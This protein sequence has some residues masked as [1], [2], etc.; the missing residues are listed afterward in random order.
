MP[1]QSEPDF[2]D[3]GRFAIKMAAIATSLDRSQKEFQTD[4]PQP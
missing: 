1:E 2:A 3:L 4:H